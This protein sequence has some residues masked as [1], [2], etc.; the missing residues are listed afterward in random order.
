M[1]GTSYRAVWLFGACAVL[2]LAAGTSAFAQDCFDDTDL[3]L[4]NG[5]IHTMDAEFSVVSAVRVANGRIVSVGVYSFA[6]VAFLVF[7]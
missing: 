3:Q 6:R 5:N 7:T 2:G 1:S 4:V